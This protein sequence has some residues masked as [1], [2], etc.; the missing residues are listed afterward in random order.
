MHRFTKCCVCLSCVGYELEG[1]T[2]LHDPSDR[3][4]P[5]A[6]CHL[7]YLQSRN[8]FFKRS[9]CH[10]CENDREKNPRENTLLATAKLVTLPT[11]SPSSHPGTQTCDFNLPKK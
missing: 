9:R 10:V 7:Y 2:P 8:F 6:S 5:G 4:I 3:A 11:P 1:S